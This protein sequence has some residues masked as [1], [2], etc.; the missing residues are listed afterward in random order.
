[1]TT[2]TDNNLVV[3]DELEDIAMLLAGRGQLAEDIDFRI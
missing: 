1:M 3:A 2:M